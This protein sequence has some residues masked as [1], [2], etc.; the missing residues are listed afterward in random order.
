MA[1]PFFTV[2]PIPVTEGMSQQDR[3][4]VL[5]A[6]MQD[7]FNRIN[8]YWFPDPEDR[9]QALERLYLVS[10]GVLDINADFGI[11][12]Y[13]NLARSYQYYFVATRQLLTEIQCLDS[14]PSY[15]DQSLPFTP[16]D[17]EQ[18]Y[19]VSS[20]SDRSKLIIAARRESP[21]LQGAIWIYD[22]DDWTLESGPTNIVYNSTAK[23][24][25]VDPTDT[26]ICY[27]PSG[28]SPDRFYIV[29]AQTGVKETLPSLPSGG[30]FD[31]TWSPDAAKLVLAHTISGGITCTEYST[32]DW[33]TTGTYFV[34]DTGENGSQTLK[35]V[36]YSPAGTWVA[37]GMANSYYTGSMPRR[38]YVWDTA[39]N[40]QAVLEG[41]KSG[42]S[43][44]GNADGI[45][46][47][48]WSIDGRYLVFCFGSDPM[49]GEPIWIYDAFDN[50]SKVTITDMPTHQIYH[51]YFHEDG[52]TMVATG[53]NNDWVY[54]MSTWTK[55]EMAGT[56][57]PGYG[58][59]LI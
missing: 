21:S 24:L 39:G 30:S 36:A 13:A 45:E 1:K 52:N 55:T 56:G 8:D 28:S 48:A 22:T 2:D 32:A 38:F 10:E 14:E 6:W 47:T 35:S 54:D 17:W 43:T 41:D 42:T 40:R 46:H 9:L 59:T 34:P 16:G 44:F 53:S 49:D 7:Q 58:V 3:D 19:D 12:L 5:M 29:N 20:L 51:I 26:Y 11:E 18:I 57:T 31:H 4:R 50:F 27:S 37:G 23:T 25:S 15:T 33:T